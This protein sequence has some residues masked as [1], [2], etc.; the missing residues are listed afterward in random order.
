MSTRPE[1]FTGLPFVA[2]DVRGIRSWDVDRYGRLISPSYKTV[3]TPG[4]NVAECKKRDEDAIYGFARGGLSAYAVDPMADYRAFIQRATAQ[5][6]SV[7]ATPRRRSI[8]APPAI[9]AAVEQSSIVKAAIESAPPVP[10]KP[11][12]TQDACEC[13][14]YAYSNGYNDYADDGRLTGVIQGYG[15]TQIGTRGFKCAKARIIALYIPEPDAQIETCIVAP[16]S[17]TFDRVAVNYPDAVVF[18]NYAEM[19][20]MFPVHDAVPTPDTDPDFWTRGI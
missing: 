15:E 6:A 11:S 5:A 8:F 13:G 7:T 17:R 10:E 12:H 2:G 19:V 18:T 20:E 14:F 16:Q 1:S 9:S 3:W 4:E